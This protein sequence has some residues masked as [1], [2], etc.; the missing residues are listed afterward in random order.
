MLRAART[1]LVAL[2]VVFG[3]VALPGGARGQTA[4]AVPEAPEAPEAPVATVATA[5]G[6]ADVH[7][8]LTALGSLLESRLNPAERALFTAID[9][10]HTE[11]GAAQDLLLAALD[12]LRPAVFLAF[13][14]AGYDAPAIARLRD[15]TVRDTDG[16]LALAESLDGAAAEGTAAADADRDAPDYTDNSL[17]VA[18]GLATRTAELAQAIA[19]GV[20]EDSDE[21]LAEIDRMLDEVSDILDDT[22][23]LVGRRVTVRIG[24]Q[25]YRAAVAALRGVGAHRVPVPTPTHVARVAPSD[26]PARHRG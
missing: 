20:S 2:L 14:A 6:A 26:P 4:P 3:S 8:V 15:L 25:M 5:E 12:H 24:F 1:Q 7:P 13:E 11:A 21:D 9:A 18:V 10:R 23:V 16:A 19:G 22:T 17:R